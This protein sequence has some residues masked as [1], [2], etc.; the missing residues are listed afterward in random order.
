MKELLADK[1]H[2]IWDWNGTL[3]DDL[4]LTIETNN[5][6]LKQ[7][8]MEPVSKEFYLNHFRFP[9]KEYYRILG[10]EVDN[11]QAFDKF[12][13]QFVNYYL[14][15]LDRCQVHRFM[16]DILDGIKE[17]GEK[18]QSVL[19]AADQK[20][21]NLMI[22][23]F[24]L[25]DHFVHIYGIADRQGGSKIQR[26]HELLSQL[27]SEGDIKRSDLV[28]IGDTV[29]DW[30]VAGEMGIDSI[31]VSHGHNNAERLLE[32]NKNLYTYSR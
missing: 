21:L 14:S 29:H 24:G 7:E 18:K 31:L 26:G 22:S 10:F 4:D 28:M 2:V 25:T 17:A 32:V 6:V 1:K 19:S 20:S 16:R 5:F 8:G 3:L 9:V 27:L 23:R 30:E 12:C 13:D 15:Q 11:A